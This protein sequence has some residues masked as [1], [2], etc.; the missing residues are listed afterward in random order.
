MSAPES[1]YRV[2]TDD[3]GRVTK[4]AI[5]ANCQQEKKETRAVIYY[6]RR[7]VGSRFEQVMSHGLCVAHFQSTLDEARLS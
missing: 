3:N 6:C 2:D 7:L 5:C 4:V 1:I